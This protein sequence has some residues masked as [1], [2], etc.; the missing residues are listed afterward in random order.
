MLVNTRN[1]IIIID[2]LYT[3]FTIVKKLDCTYVINVKFSNFN[4]YQVTIIL[5]SEITG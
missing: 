1:Y 4:F 2:E 5:F 3:L